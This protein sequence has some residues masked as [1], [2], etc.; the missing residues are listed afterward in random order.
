MWKAT[1]TICESANGEP[2]YA[3]VDGEPVG[4]LPLSFKIVPDALSIVTPAAK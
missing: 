4:A 1:E 3:Q 2:V